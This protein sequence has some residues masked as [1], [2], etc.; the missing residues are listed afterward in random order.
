MPFLDILSICLNTCHY[1]PLPFSKGYRPEK[2]HIVP[3]LCSLSLKKRGFH[4]ISMADHPSHATAMSHLPASLGFL[5]PVLIWA[6]PLESPISPVSQCSRDIDQR[7][8]GV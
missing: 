1:L 8:S 3:I 6:L 4:L 7:T 2:E 5:L